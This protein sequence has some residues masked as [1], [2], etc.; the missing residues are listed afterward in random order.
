MARGR[1]AA[2]HFEAIRRALAMQARATQE[3]E[4]LYSYE[5]DFSPTDMTWE[6]FV[7]QLERH[8]AAGTVDEF[9][10]QLAEMITPLI[11]E[12]FNGPR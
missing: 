6:R 10:A 11:Q 4:H 2:M 12:M 8:R 5:E 9:D 7:R 3:I 1:F